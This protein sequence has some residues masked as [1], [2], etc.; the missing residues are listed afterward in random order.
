MQEK[1]TDE[2]VTGFIKHEEVH[3]TVLIKTRH[4][5]LQT[6]AGQNYTHNRSRKRAV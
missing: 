5:G 4:Q 3:E 2:A 1:H 6:S